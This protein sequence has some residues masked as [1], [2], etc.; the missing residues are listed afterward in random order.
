MESSLFSTP[1]LQERIAAGLALRGGSRGS[2]TRCLGRLAAAAADGRTAL[3]REVLACHVEMTKLAL[4]V[5]RQEAELQAL[6]TLSAMTTCRMLDFFMV[7]ITTLAVA[8]LA[9][10][11]MSAAGVT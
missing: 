1:A 4:Q 3:R 9:S 7:A 2:L 8:D 10:A 6:S 5:I 11:T